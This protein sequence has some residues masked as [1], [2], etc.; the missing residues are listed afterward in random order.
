[1]SAREPW[2]KPFRDDPRH[3]GIFLDF[4]GAVSEVPA[5]QEEATLHPRAAEVLPKLSRRYPFCIM[6]GRRVAELASLAGIPQ[7]HYVGVHGME[8]MEEEPR[9]DPLIL[10]HLPTL[11]KARHELKIALPELSGVALEDRML[12]LSLHFGQAPELGEEAV[13][14]A[15]QIADTLGL[16]VRQ[17]RMSVELRPPIDIDKGT[18]LIYLARGW[19]LKRGLYAGSDP[20]DVEGFRGLRR[21]MRDGGFEGVAIAVLTPET[22]VELEAVADITVQGVDG[23]LDLLETL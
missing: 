19:K 5:G 17:G 13:S 2:Q 12:A 14:L 7:A 21:L 4:D 15:E 18:A 9:I 22:P 6:S 10:P 23:L 3:S 20:T 8:W 1:M 11:D 16:R